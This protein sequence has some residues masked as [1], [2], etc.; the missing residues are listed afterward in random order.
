M[1]RITQF[2]HGSGGTSEALRRHGRF[3]DE[4]LPR[5]LLAYSDQRRPVVFWN[6]TRE[7]NLRCSHCYIAA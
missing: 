3:P 4:P 2:V 6:M 1:N 5:H 7:C